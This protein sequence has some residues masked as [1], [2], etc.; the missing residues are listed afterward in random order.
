MPEPDTQQRGEVDVAIAAIPGGRRR[1]DTERVVAIAREITG[2]SGAMVG[3]IIGFGSC[4]YRYASGR[5]GDTVRIGVAGRKADLV[6]YGLQDDPGAAE[7]LVRLGPH[8]RGVGCVYLK[9]LSKVDESVL[10]ELLRRAW[11]LDRQ[12][13]LD[14]QAP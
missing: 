14:D 3:S 2:E 11:T 4:H 1:A 5:E 9:D 7:L 13:Q 12:A 6:L 10:T 8:R